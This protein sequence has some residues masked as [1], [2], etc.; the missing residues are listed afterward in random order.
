MKI[1]QLCLTI[2]LAAALTPAVFADTN[3]P[4]NPPAKHADGK[5][6]LKVIDATEA[7]KLIAAKSVVVLDVRTA[8]EFAAGQCTNCRLWWHSMPVAP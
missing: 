3:A 2:V 5:K 4:A 1:A 6:S 7:E 8:A